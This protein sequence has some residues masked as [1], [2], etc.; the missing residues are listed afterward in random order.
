MR[1]FNREQFAEL[2]CPQIFSKIIGGSTQGVYGKF[3]NY[4]DGWDEVNLIPELSTGD[5]SNYAWSSLKIEQ[6]GNTE[7]F[8]VWDLDDINKFVTPFKATMSVLAHNARNSDSTNT[9][10]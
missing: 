9:L 3:D 8:A 5:I 4:E 10:K 1:L 6:G 2:P 7:M